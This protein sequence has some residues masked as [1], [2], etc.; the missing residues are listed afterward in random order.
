M[1]KF[2]TA[3][4]LYEVLNRLKERKVLTT[5]ELN[6]DEIFILEQLVSMKLASK[7]STR[8]ITYYCYGVDAE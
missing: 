8:L 1:D 2:I 3:S 7:G 6:G 4:D 5:H